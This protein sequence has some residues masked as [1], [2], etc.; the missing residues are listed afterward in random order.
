MAGPTE[1]TDM[2]LVGDRRL[3]REVRRR[4]LRHRPHSASGTA[5]F[6]PPTIEDDTR[7]RRGT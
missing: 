7:R 4:A 1:Q 3:C 2:V 5:Q 6:N